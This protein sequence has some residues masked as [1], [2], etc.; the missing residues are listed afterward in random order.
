M[1]GK[2]HFEETSGRSSRLVCRSLCS[3]IAP[4]FNFHL[5]W[6]FQSGRPGLRL[7]NL[8]N[9]STRRMLRGL[10]Q[11]RSY[12]VKSQ[13]IYTTDKSVSFSAREFR[14]VGGGGGG[15]GGTWG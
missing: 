7:L 10:S 6:I 8:T 14:A 12:M 4:S 15:G 3:I 1:R 13:Q 9:V 11:R 2:I 5:I